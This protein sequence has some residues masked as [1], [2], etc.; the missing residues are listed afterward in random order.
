MA[1]CSA[2]GQLAETPLAKLTTSGSAFS[3][4]CWCFLEDQVFPGLLHPH[5]GPALMVLEPPL[6]DRILEASPY[7]AG[8]ALSSSIIGRLIFSMYA[9]G[10]IPTEAAFY[11]RYRC[12]RFDDGSDRS[13]RSFRTVSIKLVRV[14]FSRSA[15][16]RARA[17]NS[18]SRRRE[19]A[20]FMLRFT[21]TLGM[22]PP[23]YLTTRIAMLAT[24][25]HVLSA[26]AISECAFNRSSLRS[27]TL[28][29]CC[30]AVWA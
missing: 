18:A 21:A 30:V 15:H 16:S 25:T 4:R 17:S 6:A 3:A 29:I 24:S 8:V 11:S 27:I 22:A 23:A 14:R 12:F 10:L 28:P 19:I 1:G 5:E 7:S 9:L 26:T 13:T 20:C 2:V